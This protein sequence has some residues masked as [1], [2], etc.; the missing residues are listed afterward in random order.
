MTERVS[1]SK[2]TICQAQAPEPNNKV[3]S[4]YSR[5]HL[6]VNTKQTARACGSLRSSDVTPPQE[7]VSRTAGTVTLS[8]P[9]SPSSHHRAV[10]C[11][12]LRGPAW[13]CKH[14]P[15]SVLYYFPG[16]RNQ[17]GFLSCQVS[18]VHSAGFGDKAVTSSR[19]SCVSR[20]IPN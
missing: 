2:E 3:V 8:T 12:C 14:P 16:N 20:Q 13:P 10:G 7:P 9:L 5:R 1:P 4:A 15:P 19:S 11:R 18:V 17:V 6:N